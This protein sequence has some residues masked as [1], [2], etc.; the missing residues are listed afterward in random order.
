L[1]G[2]AALPRGPKGGRQ[3]IAE[4]ACAL[5]RGRHVRHRGRRVDARALSAQLGREAFGSAR[6][7]VRVVDTSTGAHCRANGHPACRFVP[8]P[9]P[10]AV[11]TPLQSQSA[12][13]S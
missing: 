8:F 11:Q 12:A 10:Q 4:R 7:A 1:C 3:L 13:E 6:I 9:V 5:E 2:D